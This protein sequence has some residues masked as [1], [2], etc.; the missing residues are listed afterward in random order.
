MGRKRK[1][2]GDKL[3]PV[4]TNLRPDR[5]EAIVRVARATDRTIAAVIR[6]RMEAKPI[7]V[8]YSPSA[9]P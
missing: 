8:S 3:V 4:T 6:D 9:R 1:A 7:S 2:D 5:Y